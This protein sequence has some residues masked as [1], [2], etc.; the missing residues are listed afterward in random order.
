MLPA[1]R[2]TAVTSSNVNWFVKTLSSLERVLNLQ[3]IT[4]YF[5]LHVK[6]VAALPCHT[7][8]YYT[9]NMLHCRTSPAG[10]TCFHSTEYV[11]TEQL[12]PQSV[13]L[14]NYTRY[15]AL[16]SSESIS[17]GCITLTKWSS[18]WCTFEVPWITATLTM[19]LMTGLGVFE[20]KWWTVSVSADWAVWQYTFKT[21][22]DFCR[23]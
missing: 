13:N 11:A 8:S 15:G 20:G 14:V 18:A 9:P 16:S 4:Q 21:R 17:R 19:L 22:Y 2:L 6:R 7:L 1:V 3:Q 12:R 10:N 5:P 23:N